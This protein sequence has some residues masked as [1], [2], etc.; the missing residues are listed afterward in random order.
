[1]N[2]SWTD[3]LLA[4][5]AAH[6]I[7]AGV[8]IFAIAF[9]D[10]VIILGALVPA[11]PLM[12]ATGVLIGMGELHG[13]YALLCTALGA[14]AGDGLSYWVGRR[15]GQR[16]YDIWPFRRYPQFLERGQ[17]LFARNAFK[18]ILIA[19]YVGAIRPFVP[20][21][22]G[23]AKMSFL[24]YTQAS[25]LACLSWAALFL[26]P[27]W[28]LG[29]AYEAVAAVAG[30]LFWVLALL[31]GL[32]ALVWILLLH[33]YRWSANRF[34]DWVRHLLQ[35]AQKWP[36]LGPYWRH[37]F[38]P[39]RREALPL[40]LLAIL[41]LLLGWSG[42]ALLMLVSGHNQPL[43]IDLFVHHT[44]LALRNPLAD[45]PMVAL[46]V[47]GDWQVLAP[48]FGIGM[49]YLLW[50]Q[51]YMAAIH[52]SLAL[53]LGL[54]LTLIIGHTIEVVRPPLASSGFEFPSVAVTAATIIFGFFA[55]LVG[56]E[57]PGRNRVWPYLVS[58]IVV[59]AIGFSRIYLGAH[60]LS[61]VLGGMAFGIFW[62]LLLGS[63]YRQRYQRSFWI[64]PLVILFYGSFIVAA[65]WYAPRNL[66]AQLARFEPA[67]ED[68]Q[69]VDKQHWWD[70]GWDA[71]PIQRHEL[72]DDQRWPLDVQ[73]SGSLEVLRAHLEL[74]GW[75]SQPQAGWQQ[76][77]ISL[78]KNATA[79]QMPVLPAT[80][81]THNESLL[82][83]HPG[84]HEHELYALRLWPTDIVLTPEH[85]PLWQ[86][87]I[88]TLYYQRHFDLFGLW[89]PQHETPLAQD[90]LKEA[91][92]NLPNRWHPQRQTQRPV[93]LLQIPE[94]V[95]KDVEM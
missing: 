27:G 80:V 7:L 12:I 10:A 44:M 9:S 54:L 25:G 53:V 59:T 5:L 33:S 36:Y 18:S 47:L 79:Q 50:R 15:W 1:M 65:V 77:L 26:L 11:L 67:Q 16:L 84:R 13:P 58:G 61:D 92:A 41:W 94:E 4:W 90:A 19:R 38:D 55:V 42:F 6:P 3:T 78:D 63:A 71:L 49:A 56:R 39:N 88:Q 40:A 20:A 2:D 62:L 29:Q 37:L 52:W 81:G 69:W 95:G 75:S 48:A 86:G 60:W 51:R 93:L 22:A 14:F 30:R 64:K 17:T 73:A 34:D 43:A 28:M 31:G 46:A 87:A 35:W 32:L 23:M 83:L 24:R 45:V 57:L 76:A 72:D 82:M 74:Y 85:I 8:A 70:Q 89:L 68:L 66:E 21:I 91:V